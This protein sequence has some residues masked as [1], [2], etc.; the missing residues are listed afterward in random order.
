MN[1]LLAAQTPEE[2]FGTITAP[3]PIQPLVSQGGAGGISTVLSNLITL[4]FNVAIILFVFMVIISA[5]QWILSGG[6]KEKVASA[7]GRLTNAVIGLVILGLTWVIISV[8]GNITGI[9]LPFT[10]S[11]G[12]PRFYTPA[13]Y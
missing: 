1:N 13:P 3:S 6:D 10:T 5:L 11:W 8:I 7:R 2:V 4:I 12:G 9:A